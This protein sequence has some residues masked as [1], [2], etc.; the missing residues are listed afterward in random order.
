MIMTGRHRRILTFLAAH[1][2]LLGLV[3]QMAALDHWRPT[4]EDIR[5]IEHT[6]QHAAHCHGAAASCAEGGGVSMTAT[7]APASVPVAPPLRSVVSIASDAVPSE[8]PT[9]DILHPPRAA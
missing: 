9:A 7:A 5:G 2:A 4:I 1:I 6:H 8:A 3:F